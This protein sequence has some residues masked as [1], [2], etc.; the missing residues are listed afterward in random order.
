MKKFISILLVVAMLCTV[1]A[2]CGES[3]GNTQEDKTTFTIGLIDEGSTDAT[4]KP[5]RDSLEQS[6]VALGGSYVYA[7]LNESSADGMVNAISNLL[8]KNVDGVI[9]GNQVTMYGLIGTV[10]DMCNEAQVYWSLFWT[11]L[12]EGTE[13]YDAAM[14]SP[15]FI[16]TS[17]EDD[18][19][20]GYFAAKSVAEAGATKV[21]TITL[22]EGMVTT[23]MRNEG[24]MKAA[25]EYG[26]K[27]LGSCSDPSLTTTAAGGAT[28]TE[29]FLAA[30][31]KLDGIVILGMSQFVLSG[32]VQALENAGRT[33]ISIGCIDFNEFQADYMKSGMLDGMIGGHFAGPTYSAI[34]MANKITGNPL[35]E[36]GQ[37]IRNG[38]L[39]LSSGEDAELYATQI[40]GKCLYTDE[41]LANC[42]VKNNPNFTYED[43]LKMAEAYSIEDIIA[44]TQ[45]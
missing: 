32:V 15:Y 37:I 39:E 2:A 43:L 21:C 4:S 35:V 36:G 27:V 45:K 1:L 38:F 5:L 22:P 17:C 40:Y 19:Y 10:A 9:L 28:I 31:P 6:I 11:N 41:E 13:D 34:L 33:D 30:Y 23:N 29:D 8:S 14:N 42:L 18:V 12:E 26:M 3:G 20:S 16:S 7:T 24:L 44:R 25:K